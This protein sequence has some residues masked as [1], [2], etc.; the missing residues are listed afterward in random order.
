MDCYLQKPVGHGVKEA[1]RKRNT[2]LIEIT[3]EGEICEG[4]N[5]HDKCEL[6]SVIISPIMKQGD[7]LGAVILSSTERSLGEYESK[8]A[9][10]SAKIFSKQLGL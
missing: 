9:E 4:C 10:T 2:E 1:M 8:V 5:K 7:V 6:G 3:T